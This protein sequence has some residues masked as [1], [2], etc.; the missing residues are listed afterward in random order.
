MQGSIGRG[1]IG[2]SAKQRV[3]KN[4]RVAIGGIFV[5]F[6]DIIIPP[7]MATQIPS[8]PGPSTPLTESYTYHSPQPTAAGPYILGVD[9][10]GRGPVLGP[11]V[12]GI[13]YCP[14]A[15]QDKMEE[16]G[17]AGALVANHS[18]RNGVCAYGGGRCAA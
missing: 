18:G 7:I 13:A 16:L 11:L 15:Y 10:A 9:E 2:S 5:F 3:N 1:Y 17:F 6:L 14:A 8:A 12:Y 4:E